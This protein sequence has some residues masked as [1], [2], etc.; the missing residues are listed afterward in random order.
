MG[1]QNA[2]DLLAG[3]TIW[4]KSDGPLDVLKSPTGDF[5]DLVNTYEGFGYVSDSNLSTIGVL[6]SYL[7]FQAVP[8]I[9]NCCSWFTAMSSSLNAAI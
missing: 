2:K 5:L 3:T 1:E 9:N 8:Q 7:L 4:Q 6:K